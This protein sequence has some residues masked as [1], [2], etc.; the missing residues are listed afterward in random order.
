MSS[1]NSRERCSVELQ[2]RNRISLA[3]KN[4]KQSSW[5]KIHEGI[6]IFDPQVLVSNLQSCETFKVQNAKISATTAV[7]DVQMTES[8]QAANCEGR[9]GT[10]HNGIVAQFYLQMLVS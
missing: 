1:M 10:D 5:A 4:L 7:S 8:Y 2:S 3:M 6:I 9:A